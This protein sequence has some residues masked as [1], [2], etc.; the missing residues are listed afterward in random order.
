MSPSEREIATDIAWQ[1]LYTPYHWGGDD[2]MG[3]FDC[4]GMI[5]EILSS[6]GLIGRS[7][8][9]TAQGLWDLFKDK[10]VPEP[11]EGCLVFWTN[12]NGEVIHVEYC[13]DEIRA[14]GAS[15]GGS[16]TTTL[17]AA[18]EQNAFIKIRP[19]H[20]RSGV[21]GYVDPWKED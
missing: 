9:Y 17:Y 1:L 13:I 16:R 10:R 8:D 3:G 14:I 18:K 12:R 15:G 7:D 5:V 2:P 6:I 11:Y 21:Y 19:I 20:S 4:S